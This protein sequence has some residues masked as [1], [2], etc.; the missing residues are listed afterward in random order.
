M[1]SDKNI[2]CTSCFF[3][4]WLLGDENKKLFN[5]DKNMFYII[6]FIVLGW[7]STKGG[8]SNRL[9]GINQI[10][11]YSVCTFLGWLSAKLI[12]KKS[13]V[14]GHETGE[15][16]V[17]DGVFTRTETNEEGESTTTLGLMSGGG[18]VLEGGGFISHIRARMEQAGST[19]GR[20][21]LRKDW[22]EN[23]GM[24]EDCL[25]ENNPRFREKQ[26]QWCNERGLPDNCDL[27]AP[28]PELQGYAQ[29]KVHLCELGYGYNCSTEYGW[30]EGE[31]GA[32]IPPE[33]GHIV[34]LTGV[35]LDRNYRWC[36]RDN[37]DAREEAER[38]QTDRGNKLQEKRECGIPSPQLPCPCEDCISNQKTVSEC[39]ALNLCERGEGHNCDCIS[40]SHR[41]SS[42]T[43][44]RIKDTNLRR[45]CEAEGRNCVGEWGPY[46]ECTKECTEEGGEPGRRISRY[47]VTHE[48]DD[49]CKRVADCPFHTGSIRSYE[50]G[51]GGGL[52]I[53]PISCDDLR[54]K[55]EREAYLETPEGQAEQE[56]QRERE[57]EMIEM[58]RSGR[59]S[60]G[61]R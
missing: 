47:T 27:D 32:E 26:K 51:A 7:L 61:P 16:H 23:R 44:Q 8:L 5:I 33:D 24:R 58:V 2:L 52:G 43:L 11:M 38:T 12:K 37:R 57:R 31:L 50:C 60:I 55:R 36:A 18:L 48:A 22:C 1:K 53:S 4:G 13:L 41:E 56:A 21:A 25:D 15:A 54:T 45:R 40:D 42:E 9:L 35:T 49:E 59:I 17:H 10:I 34:D 30:K 6:P 20:D 14:E 29:G 19:E 3:V 46:E 39:E 28:C